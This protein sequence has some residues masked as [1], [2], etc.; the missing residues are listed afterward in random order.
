MQFP[1]K[2]LFLLGVLMGLVTGSP[3]FAQSTYDP[4]LLEVKRIFS[5][6]EN[7]ALSEPF[8]GISTEDGAPSDLFPD[9]RPE[10]LLP[11]FW[12]LQEISWAR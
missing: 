9:V 1:P 10:S 12:T 4:E 5:D 7:A 11:R 8:K 2:S 3:T 6:V